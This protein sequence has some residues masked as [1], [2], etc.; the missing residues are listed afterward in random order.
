VVHLSLKCLLFYL[1]D[2]VLQFLVDPSLFID[3]LLLL[4]PGPFDCR[5]SVRSSDAKLSQVLPSSKPDISVHSLVSSFVHNYVP[6][7]LTS[8]S[9][10]DVLD[11]RSD[12]LLGKSKRLDWLSRDNLNVSNFHC[13]RNCRLSFSS[14]PSSLLPRLVSAT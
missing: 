12:Y 11:S 6:V 1:L 8:D 14:L 7:A 5:D 9:F 10:K 3:L 2:L 13:S 4:S